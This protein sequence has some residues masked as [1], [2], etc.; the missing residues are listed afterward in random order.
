[1]SE[2]ASYGV[3]AL[4]GS[5][6]MYSY[7]PVCPTCE[8][9]FRPCTADNIPNKTRMYQLLLS[10]QLGNALPQ[11]MSFTE[12]DN[13]PETLQ[14]SH[15][16][17]RSLLA[18]DKRCFMDVATH[19]VPDLIK[20]HFPDG[21]CNLSPM[22]DKWATLRAE[23]WDSPTGLRIFGAISD[24]TLDGQADWQRQCGRCPNSVKWR[25]MM[26]YYASEFKDMSARCMLQHFMNPHSYNDFEHLLDRFPGHVVEFTTLGCDRGKVPGRNTIIW[27]VR[28]Y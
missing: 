17:I 14:Y 7:R 26:R 20:N 11:W 5:Y 22:V 25:D 28:N 3:C 1:M 9:Q 2:L 21:R 24:N 6:P 18:Q 4:H 15:F 27:E 13:D 19:D 12:W 10:G 23:V 8:G 16:G